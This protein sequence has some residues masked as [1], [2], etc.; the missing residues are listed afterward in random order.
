MPASTA[1]AL[2]LF[3]SLLFGTSLSGACQHTDC[4]P[5]QAA[6][7]RPGNAGS[8]VVPHQSSQTMPLEAVSGLLWTVLTNSA[9]I[10][11]CTSPIWSTL[12]IRDDVGRGA[13]ARILPQRVHVRRPVHGTYCQTF[14]CRSHE[15]DM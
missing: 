12:R 2:R 9:H 10:S 8:I 1:S 5:A 7:T 15:P 4:G 11:S 6:N 13:E 14:N 3:A